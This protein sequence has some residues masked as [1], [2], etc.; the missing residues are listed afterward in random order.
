MD[1]PFHFQMTVPQPFSYTRRH[2]RVDIARFS[3]YN[4]SQDPAKCEKRLTGDENCQYAK[5][6][7]Q[8]KRGT[9]KHRHR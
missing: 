8:V 1:I 3:R 9:G 7:L 6:K 5:Q 2:T 4:T